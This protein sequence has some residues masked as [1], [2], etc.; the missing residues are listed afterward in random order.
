MDYIDTIPFLA[1]AASFRS[2][3]ERIDGFLALK[4]EHTLRVLEQAR[5]IAAAEP[6]FAAPLPRRALLL[7]ALYHDLGR[8][9]QFRR[10]RTFAD[11]R[12]CDHGRLGKTILR[13]KGFLRA[14]PAEVRR[15]VRTAVALHNRHALPDGLAGVG[16][17]VTQGVRDADKLDILRL[18]AEQ[19]A[20]GV[21]A[22]SVVLMG[23][24]NA[25]ERWSPLVLSA[26][27]E[28]R[29]ASF[30]DMRFY[31]DFR[32]LL[33]SWLYDLAFAASF[34]KLRDAGYLEEIIGGLAPVPVAQARARRAVAGCFR[35]GSQ[36]LRE[37]TPCP[38][39]LPDR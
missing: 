30:R 17:L 12:S 2:G 20:P 22:D 13:R 6:A 14:E 35:D 31:N 36:D 9:A 18:M 32:L 28:G 34:R 24:E 25:P 27:E 4:E 3:E 8:F 5:G 26:L 21:V 11:A 16:R 23:L 33:C 15:L 37:K 10:Y 19:L 39:M 7:A 1:Y 38:P 29:T